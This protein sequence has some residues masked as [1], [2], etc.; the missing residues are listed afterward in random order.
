MRTRL[1]KCLRMSL[2]VAGL[3]P[4]RQSSYRQSSYRPIPFVGRILEADVAEDMV[5]T[6]ASKSSWVMA[7]RTTVAGSWNTPLCSPHHAPR[8]RANPI[9]G[10]RP[11]LSVV[12]EPCG[13]RERHDVERLTRQYGWDAKLTDLL[14]ALVAVAR[15]AALDGV[16]MNGASGVERRG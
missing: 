1:S 12:C 13:R 4:C 2:T 14:P 15:K 10:P 7:M 3:R 11:V 6:M 5:E 16:F 8:S 9:R